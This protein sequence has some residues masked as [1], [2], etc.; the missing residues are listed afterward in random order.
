MNPST[1]EV[2][3][4]ASKL[5]KQALEVMNK[6]ELLADH[7]ITK[8]EKLLDAAWCRYNRRAART[9]EAAY[10]HWGDL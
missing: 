9:N 5:Q 8:A 2:Y 6:L 7:G 10:H 4:A 3:Q 1:F